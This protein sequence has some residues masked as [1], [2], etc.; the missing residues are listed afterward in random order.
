V[1]GQRPP[2][3]ADAKENAALV[4]R[5]ARRRVVVVDDAAVRAAVVR[6][7]QTPA[8]II[9]ELDDHEVASLHGG[10]ERGE[11]ALTR[12]RARGSSR[13]GVVHDR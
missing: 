13:D 7:G 3:R 5:L 9:P 2:V 11:A 6:R 12:V 10:C 4:G 1:V 8:V